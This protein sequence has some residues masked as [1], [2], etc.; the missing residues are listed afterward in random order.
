MKKIDLLCNAHLDPVWLWEWEEGAA[1]AISTFRVAAEL[2]EQ[3]ENFIFNHNEALLYRWV[4]E[5][6]PALFKRIQHLVKSGRWHIMGGWFLQPDCN[7]PSGE[8]FVRQILVGRRYFREKFNVLPT[9]AI[10]FDPFGHTRGLVQIMAKSGYDSYI[11]C[12]PSP[13]DCPLPA[14]DFI[15]VGYDGSKITG[16]RTKNWYNSRLG[17]ARDKVEQ[18]LVDSPDRDVSLILWG[19]GNHGGGPSRG[20]V[21][22]LEALI[23][24][25]DNFDIRHATPEMYFADLKE[26][27]KQLPEHLGDI[28]PW[29]VGCYTSQVRIKQYHRLLENTYYAVEKMAATAA[30]YGILPYPKKELT[31]ALD[32]LLMAEFHDILP[33]S[34]I[35][36]VETT[37]LRLMD[38]G[39]EILSRIKARTFFALSEG[40]PKAQDGK[41]PILVYNPHPF[42]IETIIACEFQLAD[43]N[44]SGTF[45]QVKVSQ[46][47]KEFPTQVEQELSNL[48]LDWRKRVLFKAE[49]APAQMNRFDC[50]LVEQPSKPEINLRGDSG[51]IHFQTEDLDVLVN[52]STGLLERY[53]VRGVDFFQPGALRP[54]VIRDNEDPWGMT[55]RA[56]RD[57]VGVFDLMQPDEGTA[58]S[59]IHLGELPSVR[60]IEDGPVRTVIEAVLAYGK[61]AICQRYYLP[62]RGTEL[63]VEVRV[64][65]NE[66]DSMLKFS[67]PTTFSQARYLGQVAYGVSELPSNGD[68]VVAQK[69][70]AVVSENRGGALTCINEGVYGSDFLGGKL[71]LTLLRSPAYSG[72]PIGDRPIVPQDRYTP[73]IDQGERIFRFW[74]NAGQATER[75][76]AVDREALMHNEKPYALSFFPHGEGNL[77]SA[78]LVLTDNVVQV[79]AFKQAEDGK[80]FIIRLFE[81]TGRPRSTT[82]VIPGLSIR[83]DLVFEPFE[84][85]TL[86]LDPVEKHLSEAD[87]M[88]NLCS[89]LEI[90]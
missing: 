61:S 50:E 26:S 78:G 69:W 34:S 43:Q 58:F 36:P 33:G 48:S 42:P 30:L 68:E 57:L 76:T 41:I 40:Q 87:L 83:K 6:E 7:L 17:Q 8:S 23:E 73:R 9:T 90:E 62:K 85:K 64:H 65:W 18:F 77:P 22:A 47:E 25:T 29:A 24:E 28:N 32:D 15:W 37:S 56:F 39:L 20:D 54:L 14:D 19:V 63:E 67:V 75:L 31:A 82:L 59:G 21:Y 45:T 11:F 52:T 1:E 74:F 46:G 55:T 44:Y 12:R 66:K 2:C 4:E 27:G 81:P 72:H 89:Q 79:S 35:Q 5:Y 84:I 16:H 49:L 51:T 71:R 53:R 86:Y 13:S 80:G 10:N 60:I 70:V 3:Y 38:H 88:E